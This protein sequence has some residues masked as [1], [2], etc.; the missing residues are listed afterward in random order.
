LPPDRR[1]AGSLPPFTRYVASRAFCWLVVRALVRVR[2]EGGELLPAGPAIFC[3][4]H[5][6]WAD[7]IVL[8]AALPLRRRFAL[9]G[10]SE[11]NMR[12]GR[13]NRLMAWSGLAVP[14]RPGKNDLLDTTRRVQ[15]VLDA[16]WSLA[17]A[18]EGRIHVGERELLPLSEGVAYFALRAGVPVVPIAING[19]GWLGFGRTVRVRVGEAILAPGR[20][21]RPAVAE[22]T[23]RTTDALRTLMADFED[24]PPPGPVG[25]WL[26]EVF[27]DWPE[28]SRPDRPP[29]GDPAQGN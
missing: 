29:E 6:S 13:R 3:I 25:R 19:T 7:P 23:A 10:P 9:F 28:G 4:N 1:G 18:A 21:T 2:F 15:A 16:G 27:N 20:P 11:E 12:V 22:L 26:T 5:Q 8:L 14:Y 24:R 17:I